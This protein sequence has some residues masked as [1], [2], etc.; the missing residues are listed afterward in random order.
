MSYRHDI[1]I[2]PT[3]Q[4]RKQCLSTMF[5]NA[6]T[7]YVCMYIGYQSPSWPSRRCFHPTLRGSDELDFVGHRKK[8][9]EKTDI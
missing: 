6:I 1:V 2:T 8:K 9:E 4:K 3:S 5:P 7:T